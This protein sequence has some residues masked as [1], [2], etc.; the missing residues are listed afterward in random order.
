MV[1]SKH[2]TSLR[3]CRCCCCCCCGCGGAPPSPALAAGGGEGPERATPAKT[4]VT[5]WQA[6]PC[7]PRAFSSSQL[8]R[9]GGRHHGTHGTHAAERGWLRGRQL[10]TTQRSQTDTLT[11]HAAARRSRS[12]AHLSLSYRFGAAAPRA[13]PRPCSERIQPR[14]PGTSDSEPRPPWTRGLLWWRT[15]PGRLGRRRKQR[16]GGPGGRWC[17]LRGYGVGSERVL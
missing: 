12:A 16:T 6:Q 13:D 3:S 8:R 5:V 15:D 7:Q 14:E 2:L 9:R 11:E 4:C 10:R 17:R 1:P